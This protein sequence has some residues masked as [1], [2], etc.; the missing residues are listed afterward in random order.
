MGYA[1]DSE[2]MGL[3]E[4]KTWV[5]SANYAD[6]SL[7]RNALTYKLSRDIGEYAPA[8][9]NFE[10]FLFNDSSYGKNVPWNALSAFNKKNYRGVYLLVERIERDGN[11]LDVQ[12]LSPG[13]NSEPEI[14]GKIRWDLMKLT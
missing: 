4:G 11:R 12:K 9:R 10:L 7:M 6:K 5:L 1:M 14:S 13:D 2:L 8:F 3:P